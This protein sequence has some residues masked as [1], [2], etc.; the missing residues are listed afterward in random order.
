LSSSNNASNSDAD[1]NHQE[2]N[3]PD[4]NDPDVNDIEDR[5][6]LEEPTGSNYNG[7]F[8]AFAIQQKGYRLDGLAGEAELRKKDSDDSK[9][10]LKPEAN[11]EETRPTPGVPEAAV[12][13]PDTEF[14][15]PKYRKPKGHSGGKRQFRSLPLQGGRPP[16]KVKE[17]EFTAS[18]TTIHIPKA[19]ANLIWHKAFFAGE[20]SYGYVPP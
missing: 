14:E 12:L 13:P 5:N 9:A 10:D 11:K 4:D 6:A 19:L 18:L 15:F 8:Y 20:T 16:A 17:T 1:N 2:D 3:S 7:P